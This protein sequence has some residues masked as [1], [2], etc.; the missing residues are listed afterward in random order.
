MKL[1]SQ[2]LAVIATIT[3]AIPAAYALQGECLYSMKQLA[4]YCSPYDPSNKPCRD[5]KNWIAGNCTPAVLK[6]ERDQD[7]P[8]LVEDIRD[9][10][11][12]DDRR[13]D[14]NMLC[15]EWL[16]TQD[17]DDR[18]LI[19]SILSG[20]TGENQASPDETEQQQ[21]EPQTGKQMLAKCPDIDTII[22]RGWRGDL[23]DHFRFNCA[24]A[25]F[26]GQDRTA[27]CQI[28]DRLPS[29]SM[30][31]QCAYCDE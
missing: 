13:R 27:N 21:S 8:K 30:K 17:A 31:H 18:E 5:L 28:L 9:K 24:A 4:L 11:P 29:G 14:F 16:S 2:L 6:R 25:C 19:E 23:N 26:G 12:H 22:D 1:L 15:D 7:C 3:I 20:Q 10:G